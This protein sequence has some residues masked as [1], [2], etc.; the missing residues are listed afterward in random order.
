MTTPLRISVEGDIDVSTVDEVVNASRR[1]DRRFRGDLVPQIWGLDL[2]PRSRVAAR[3]V[4]HRDRY[5]RRTDPR[6]SSDPLRTA[7]AHRRRCCG[8]RPSDTRP[9]SRACAAVRR[10]VRHSLWARRGF[11]RGR[12]RGPFAVVVHGA[13][14]RCQ[15]IL[16]DR[17]RHAER[18][19]SS[20]RT[21]ARRTR[22]SHA[23]ARGSPHGRHHH[24][25]DGAGNAAA[26]HRSSPRG[27]GPA[28][29]R[30]KAARHH[31]RARVRHRRCG[32]ASSRS[33]CAVGSAARR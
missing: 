23:R 3:E 20:T 28:A 4:P 22:A 12:T 6:S 27:C 8:S 7:S 11:V 25:H 10:L 2:L 9:R 21:G 15:R 13:A 29:G 31:W 17:A 32:A 33:R 1:G 24:V 16:A 18:R 26:R 5:G 30:A 19:L 14:C